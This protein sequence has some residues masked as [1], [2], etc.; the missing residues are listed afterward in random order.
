MMARRTGEGKYTHELSEH[1][2][3]YE[4]MKSE[5]MKLHQETGDW[6]DPGN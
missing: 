5:M 4:E 1:L 6:N 2:E 3:D